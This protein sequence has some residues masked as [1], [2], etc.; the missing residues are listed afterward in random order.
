MANELPFCNRTVEEACWGF[1]GKTRE[2]VHR[3]VQAEADALAIYN[4]ATNE[5]LKS[6]IPPEQHPIELYRTFKAS[7]DEAYSRYKV[8]LGNL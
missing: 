2:I 5:L 7:L 6:G 8:E 1:E 4:T 3:F